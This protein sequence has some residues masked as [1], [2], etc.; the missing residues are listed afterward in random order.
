MRGLDKFMSKRRVSTT[1]Y[2]NLFE[3]ESDEVNDYNDK[4]ITSYNQWSTSDGVHFLPTASTVDKLYP[5]TYDI[6]SSQSH[7]IYF[8]KIPVVTK[9][10]LRFPETNSDKI[11]NEIQKFWD[12]E[13]IFKEYN[14]TYKRGVMLYGPQIGRAHV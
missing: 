4:K 1:S 10:I 6:K 5:G 2:K 8:E 7:G 11:V 3:L 12:R 14:L 13:D 9:G